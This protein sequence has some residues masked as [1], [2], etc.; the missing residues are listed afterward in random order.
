MDHAFGFQTV[1]LR[2]NPTRFLSY[3]FII[4]FIILFICS[5]YFCFYLL[6]YFTIRYFLIK[7]GILFTNF[8]RLEF[9]CMFSFVSLLFS[10]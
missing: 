8:V 4:L 7:H 6:M 5:L 10:F 3:L 9:E 2:S 1:D